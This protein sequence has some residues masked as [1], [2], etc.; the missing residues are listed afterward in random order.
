MLSRYRKWRDRRY[1]NSLT[2]Q[3]VVLG[4]QRFRVTARHGKIIGIEM[5]FEPTTDSGAYGY[6][7][8]KADA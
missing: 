7:V 2:S 1:W 5:W 6:H 8:W 4:G 3:A